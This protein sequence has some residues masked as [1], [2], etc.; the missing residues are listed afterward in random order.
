MCSS[1]LEERFSVDLQKFSRGHPETALEAQYV[2]GRQDQAQ[3]RTAGGEAGDSGVA[4]ETEAL[5]GFEWHELRLE[6]V[7]V[8]GRLWA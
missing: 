7:G 1:D 2:V 3:F 5:A 4:V 6:R 8:S